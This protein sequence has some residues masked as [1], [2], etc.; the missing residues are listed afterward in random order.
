M[1]NQLLLLFLLVFSLSWAQSGVE[2]A[3]VWDGGLMFST[4]EPLEIKMTYSIKELK[5]QTNDSVYMPT[6]ISYL[7]QDG[8]WVA[9]ET[10]IRTRGNFRLANCYFPPVKIK[11]KKKVAKGTV[12]EG[13][14]SLKM[15]F[16]CLRQND[17]DDNV[18]KELMAYKIYQGVSPYH[19]KTRLLNIELTE[20]RG[21]DEGIHQVKGFFIEDVDEMAERYGG[22][23]LERSIHP[24]EQDNICSARNDFFQYMIGN[25]DFSIAYQHNEKL[26]F[27]DKKIIP[28]P[29]DFDMSGLVNA[30][31]SRV[32]VIGDEELPISSVTDR[33]YR[34]FK[35]TKECYQEIRQSFIDHQ[36]TVMNVCGDYE[37]LFRNQ[38]EYSAAVKYLQGFFEVLQD[39]DLYNK[40]I[41]L[42]A[43]EK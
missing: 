28:V 42:A 18:I 16:P 24:L 8:N 41:V 27:V 15:V 34:G 5:K 37:G 2:Q 33:M 14:R 1:K 38:K 21:G 20:L 7:D 13:N 26:I 12:F 11:L 32:S 40:K 9:L 25:T 29:Y 10:R 35:R 43:R 39:D 31:Y 36:P 17:K 4:D 6:T 3:A 22:K 19:F 23:E 30:S